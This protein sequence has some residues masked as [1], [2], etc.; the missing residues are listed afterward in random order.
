MTT[1][2]YYAHAPVEAQKVAD[3]ARIHTLPHHFGRHMLIVEDAVYRWMHR[4]APEYSGATGIS[5]SS[6]TAAS[7]WPRSAHRC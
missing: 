2:A 7:T 1:A 5:T 3:D 4:L 6:R